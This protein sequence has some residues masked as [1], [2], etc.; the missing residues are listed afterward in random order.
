MVV[1]LSGTSANTLD[2]GESHHI[3]AGPEEQLGGMNV[4][5]YHREEDEEEEGMKEEILR[6]R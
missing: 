3:E 2:F 1:W 5:T 6:S 4:S